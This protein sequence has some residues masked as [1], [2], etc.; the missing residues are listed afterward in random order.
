MKSAAENLVVTRNVTVKTLLE[1][2][3]I[4]GTGQLEN[5]RKRLFHNLGVKFFKE[6]A[7]ALRLQPTEYRI[8]NFDMGSNES[9]EVWLHTNSLYLQMG[10]NFPPIESNVSPFKVRKCT[11]LTHYPERDDRVWWMPF[12]AIESVTTCRDW[13]L[14]FKAQSMFGGHDNG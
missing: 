1:G 9:G 2:L 8:S 3:P 4:I 10:Q 14:E 5:A 13:I 7:I 6:V 11:A 12:S